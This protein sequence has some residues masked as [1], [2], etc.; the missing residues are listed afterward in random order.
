LDLEA[1]TV[2]VARTPATGRWLLTSQ[3]GGTLEVG[4]TGWRDISALRNTANWNGTIRIR[5]RGYT[6]TL[7]AEVTPTDIRNWQILPTIPAGFE[8]SAWSGNAAN[9]VIV[10]RTDGSAISFQLSSISP[11]WFYNAPLSGGAGIALA[12]TDTVYMS[13]TW[14]TEAVWPSSLPG[15]VL[16][17]PRTGAPTDYHGLPEEHEPHPTPIERVVEP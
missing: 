8:P 17:Q 11:L 12:T 5:R 10:R 3:D 2:K 1:Q 4:D 14:E 6:V 15:T 16:G 13:I 9:P 7:T